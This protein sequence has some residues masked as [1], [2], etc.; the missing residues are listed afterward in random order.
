[1][2]CYV[3]EYQTFAFG[4]RAL[5][6]NRTVPQMLN[7]NLEA[8]KE[9]PRQYPL[10][11]ATSLPTCTYPFIVIMSSSTQLVDSTNALPSEI[12]AVLEKYENSRNNGSPDLFLAPGLAASTASIEDIIAEIKSNG[13][14]GT[15][16]TYLVEQKA[17]LEWCENN[18][19]FPAISKTL[20]TEEKLLI[21]LHS[22]VW[23]RPLKRKRKASDEDVPQTVGI[24]SIKNAASAMVNLWTVQRIR[25]VNN[26]PSPR[27]PLVKEFIKHVK[28]KEFERCRAEFVNRGIGSHADGYTNEKEFIKL[29]NAFL[30][31]SNSAPHNIRD[32]AM[33]LLAHYGVMRGQNARFLEF[34][35]L[36]LVELTNIRPSKCMALNLVLKNGKMNQVNKIEHGAMIRAKN[37]NVC[38]LG[39]LAL[40]LFQHFEIEGH[41]FPDLQ[42]RKNWF[43][44]K[45][46]HSP[47]D[48]FAT[49]S[50]TTHNKAFGAAL[51]QADIR[52]S[53]KT[54]ITRKCPANAAQKMDDDKY[55]RQ[56][57]W[58]KGAMDLCYMPIPHEA[59]L[60]LAGFDSAHSYHV[61]RSVIEPPVI[62]QKLIF[63]ELDGWLEKDKSQT[64]VNCSIST[65]QF[66]RVLEYLRIVILQDSVP[67]MEEFP[68]LPTWSHSV[69]HCT[70]Y[71][72]FR[73]EV[74]KVLNE[75]KQPA[76]VTLQNLVPQLLSFEQTQHASTQA[77]LEALSC[78]MHS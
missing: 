50:Y 13:N 32:R 12:S 59:V 56:G 9:S 35:D 75:G 44:R 6:H 77:K 49:I 37:V 30:N 46:F 27:G 52:S 34:A 54:H 21:F 58:G 57:R 7:S 28:T 39:A 64:G 63:K 47:T 11:P 51:K 23:K 78:Q 40:H 22:Q 62:L 43:T 26:H 70:E 68:D 19:A 16:K 53:K 66:L 60:G 71:T 8:A 67:L 61:A 1:M 42:S 38:A 25:G 5:R 17:F 18:P 24:Q 3:P 74:K 72:L 4:I 45:V 10:H 29:A 48:T 69:F 2:S 65:T 55:K 14:P 15:T 73:D 41:P 31:S 20:V 76:E 33:F 36:Q